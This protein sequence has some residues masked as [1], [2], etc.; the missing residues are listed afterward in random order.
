MNEVTQRSENG[1]SG[2]AIVCTSAAWVREKDAFPHPHPLPPTTGGRAGP[3]VMRAG[4]LILP[5]TCNSTQ[6][7]TPCMGSTVDLALDMGVAGELA[8]RV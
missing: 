2:Y 8:L 6:G 1:T 3:G 7:P 5:L 4:E